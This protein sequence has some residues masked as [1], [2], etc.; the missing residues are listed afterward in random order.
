[1]FSVGDH[2]IYGS[3]G[4]CLVTAIG[5]SPCGGQDDRLYYTLKPMDDV[6]NSTIFTPVDNEK[7]PMRSLLTQREAGEL[8]E[9]IPQIPAVPM[10]NGKERVE[11]YKQA[12]A[13]ADPESYIAVLKAVRFKRSELTDSRK[14][15]SDVDT[16]F[17][18]QA[19]HSLCVELSVA[20]KIPFSE[21]ESCVE[22]KLV[23]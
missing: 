3:S 12:M 16:S 22:R 19:K 8:L 5:P 10:P 14:R 15:L 11:V 21:A 2:I 1:M 23:I 9:R 18:K 4:V 20:L 13:K 7:V 6:C 17:E